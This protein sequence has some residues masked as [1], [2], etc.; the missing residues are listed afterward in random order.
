MSQKRALDIQI[1]K[2]MD[3]LNESVKQA[4]RGGQKTLREWVRERA[5]A[6]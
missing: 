3:L 4:E 5:V 1:G 2:T 6:E